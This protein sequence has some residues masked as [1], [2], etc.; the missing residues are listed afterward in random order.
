MFLRTCRTYLI[1]IFGI[2]QWDFARPDL[3]A[4]GWW[5]TLGPK[6]PPPPTREPAGQHF[7]VSLVASWSF[8][9]C[10]AFRT[11][12]KT[13]TGRPAGQHFQIWMVAGC[14]PCAWFA[15]KKF[16]TKWAQE[17]QA[18]IFEF[19]L[20]SAGSRVFDGDRAAKLACCSCVHFVPNLLVATQAHGV[21]PATI[22]I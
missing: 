16:K 13:H 17:Q 7:S 1:K 5:G 3:G 10:F 6:P 4:G 9:V 12:S 2:L 8:C 14:A 15:T 19:R 20:W 21:Q 22:Q 18:S 11:K